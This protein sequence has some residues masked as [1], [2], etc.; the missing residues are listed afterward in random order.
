[1][2]LLAYESLFAMAVLRPL[3]TSRVTLV[4]ACSTGSSSASSASAMPSSIT[5][6]SVLRSANDC[7][8]P[9]GSGAALAP[10]SECR[11]PWRRRPSV[12]CLARAETR[13][14]SGKFKSLSKPFV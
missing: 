5:L 2:R 7:T 10:P 9:P 3:R 11:A 6:S 13:F 1:M 8:T 12:A 14:A 4:A